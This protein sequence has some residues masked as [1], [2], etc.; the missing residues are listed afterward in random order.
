MNTDQTRRTPDEY[1]YVQQYEHITM[2]IYA[3]WYRKANNIHIFIINQVIKT[4]F[5][6]IELC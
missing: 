2:F 6:E 5:Q 1:T 3:V 4:F